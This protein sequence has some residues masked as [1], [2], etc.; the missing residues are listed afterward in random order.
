MF[1]AAFFWLYQELCL[2]IHQQAELKINTLEQCS[3][4]LC[5]G[6]KG[7]FIIDVLTIGPSHK[8]LTMPRIVMVAPKP[9]HP[10]PLIQSMIQGCICYP[11]VLSQQF[12]VQV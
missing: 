2:E 6:G 8:S 7:A 10:K 12:P 11:S 1:S 4:T 5:V 3:L 9:I